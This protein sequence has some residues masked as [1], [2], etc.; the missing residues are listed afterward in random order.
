[1]T[2]E[3]LRLINHER[4]V[5]EILRI[6]E[7]KEK[8]GGEKPWWQILLESPGGAALITVLIGGLA[9]TLITGIFQ[10]RQRESD[11]ERAQTQ[12]TLERLRA[13]DERMQKL[14]LE[15]MTEALELAYQGIA[16]SEDVISL[17]TEALSNAPKGQRDGIRRKYIDADGEWR[18]QHAIKGF[19]L[20]YYHHSIPGFSEAWQTTDSSV[21]AY[22]DCAAQWVIAHPFYENG[23]TTGCREERRVFDV[24]LGQLQQTLA[25]APPQNTK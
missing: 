24:R 16:A 6:R 18:K 17:S 20:A 7:A 10:S 23:L 12:A 21:T 22:M 19:T 15:S 13:E 14:R 8:P 2:P 9:V 5:A 11:Q 25:S 3:E 4:F 1:M